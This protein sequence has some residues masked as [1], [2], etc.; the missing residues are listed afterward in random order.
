MARAPKRLYVRDLPLHKRIPAYA[1]IYWQRALIV[2]RQ[3]WENS[4]YFL[5]FTG[6]RIMM[7]IFD[8]NE[9]VIEADRNVLVH[10][11]RYRSGNL[12]RGRHDFKLKR[13]EVFLYMGDWNFD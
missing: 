10:G 12:T 4:R 7:W 3:A 5:L 9:L 11:R 2:P 1:Q 6:V 13:G 8:G